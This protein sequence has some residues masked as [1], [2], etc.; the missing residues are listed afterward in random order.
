MDHLFPHHL[1]FFSRQ[2]SSLVL[3]LELHFPQIRHPCA[4]DASL[5]WLLRHLRCHLHRQHSSIQLN[6]QYHYLD[7]QHHLRRSARYSS[8]ARPQ[9][10]AQGSLHSRQIWLCR[11]CFFCRLDDPEWHLSLLSG[12]EPY[13]FGFHELVSP[14]TISTLY[15]HNLLTLFLVT[16]SFC[17]A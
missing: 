12:L 15:D 16:L 7:A 17:S 3:I 11:Q 8:Y 4:H 1:G 14:V 2:R 9:M 5:S 13:Y 10:V 6:R